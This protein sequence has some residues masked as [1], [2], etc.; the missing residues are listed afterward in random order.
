MGVY[1]AVTAVGLCLFAIIAATLLWVVRSGQLDDLDTPAMR[2]LI[3][4]QPVKEG[5]ADE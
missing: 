5:T 4:D 1:L 2:I 3:D